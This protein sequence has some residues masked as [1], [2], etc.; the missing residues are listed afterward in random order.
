MRENIPISKLIVN[1]KNYRFDPVSNQSQAIDL[2]IEEKGN[3]ILVLAKHIY[4]KGLDKAKDLRVFEK[5]SESFILLD[6]NRRITAIKCLENPLII[7]DEHLRSKFEII[8]KGVGFIPEK[9][10]CFVYTNEKEAAEWIRLDHTG[11]N[12]GIG[13]D[14]WGAAE[15]DRFEE[16]FGGKKSAAT[17]LFD[18]YKEKTKSK[19]TAKEVKISTINRIISNPE[20]RSYIGINID[21][22]IVSWTTDEKEVIARLTTLFDKIIKDDVAVGEVYKASQSIQFVKDLFGSRPQEKKKGE[23]KLTKKVENEIPKCFVIMPLAG[24][25]SVYLTIQN[26]WKNVF[27]KNAKVNHQKDDKRKGGK[28]LME[29]KI[30]KNISKSSAVVGVLSMGEKEKVLFNS[31]SE[32]DR[33]DVFKKCFP[34][35][36]NVILEAGYALKCLDNKSIL[37]DC[38]F[39]A[40]NSDK[41]NIHKF[42]IDHCFDL[43]HRDIIPYSESDLKK[44]EQELTEYF[45]TFKEEN[46]L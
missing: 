25:E 18:F 43:G 8:L 27:G 20:A 32:E 4:E 12:G 31:I 39:I 30:F 1:P 40:D 11:R 33:D 42:L 37:K 5:N 26:A 14:S 44:L 19:I 22:G 6:G 2:M 13:Q 28:D 7:K 16:K 23:I 3:E 41:Y 24:L 38:F 46:K 34:F 9:V 21:K 15:V 45:K 10:N 36:V 17:Q 35:N 29:N